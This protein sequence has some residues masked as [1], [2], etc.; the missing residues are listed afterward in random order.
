M[1][2]P[3]RIWQCVDGHPVCEGYY[4]FFFYFNSLIMKHCPSV[5]CILSNYFFPF[6]SIYPSSYISG[7]LSLF[8]SIEIFLGCRKKL[9]SKG[10]P[11]CNRSVEGR[12]IALGI[13]NRMHCGAM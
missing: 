11:S 12:N 4:I 10:C 6:L 8:L 9:D 3:M 13:L 5:V 2:P 1:K 7:Y